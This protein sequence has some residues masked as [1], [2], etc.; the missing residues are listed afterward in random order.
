MNR[1]LTAYVEA[2]LSERPPSHHDSG[3]VFS[4]LGGRA[5][6]ML[7]LYNVT[8]DKQHLQ[9]AQEY[10]KAMISTL[11]AQK[12]QDAVTGQVG[13]LW[14]HVGMLCVAAAVAQSS[15][16]DPSSY[17]AQVASLV[18]PPYKGKYDDF[19][20]DRAG[21]IYA[22]RF[23]DE[24]IA[25]GSTVSASELLGLAT[26]I[27]DR[28]EA[29]GRANGHN[30]LQWHGPNDSGLWLGQSHGS[31]GVIQQLLAVKGILSNA[32]ASALI[33]T[34][35]D[36]LCE[37]QQ[38]SGNFPTEYYNSTEDVLVQWDHGAPGVAAV[39]LA[40]AEAFHSTRYSQAAS[41]ALECVWERGLLFKG[42]MNCH[43]IGG[44]TH[45][46][47]YAHRVTKNDTYLY[48]AIAFQ[49]TVL[50]QPILSDLDTMRRPQPEPDTPWQFWVGSIE[51]AIMLWTD[52][53]YRGPSDVRMTGWFPQI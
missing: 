23:L 45:M 21:L 8:G 40:A 10:N 27:I 34:T 4:G 33:E 6:I 9:H 29:T 22:V 52:M 1:S 3:T 12:L 25:G 7:K 46:Q 30:Y 41:K 11:G 5:L 53:I 43:G 44:N 18:K 39:L 38:P 36:N 15:G 24:N 16:D 50:D 47:L 19:D 51:S 14:S 28:G 49:T 20:S 17:V 13:F 37:Q 35:L 31:A 2:M 48:R 32:S 42:L 26:A